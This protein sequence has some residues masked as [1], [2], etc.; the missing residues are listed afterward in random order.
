MTA[1]L[2][3]LTR[4]YRRAAIPPPSELAEAKTF[5]EW[6]RIR[7]QRYPELRYL[8]HIP[9]GGYRHKATAIAMRAQGV[10]AG[11][12][13]YLWPHRRGGYTGMAIELKRRGGSTTDSQ[14]T[15]LAWLADEG[16]QT[17]VAVGADAAIAAVQAYLRLPRT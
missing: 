6:I 7:E 9:N 16:W 12:P 10:R 13:D 5:F 2:D 17:C 3:L 1:Q 8:T 14:D 11:V 4:R 15:W